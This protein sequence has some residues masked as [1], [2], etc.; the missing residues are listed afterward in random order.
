MANGSRIAV[1]IL[2]GT[3]DFQ[4]KRRPSKVDRQ[5]KERRSSYPM[6]IRRRYYKVEK[7]DAA[8]LHVEALL[9]ASNDLTC[10]W[11]V[12]A[13]EKA[14]RPRG[15]YMLRQGICVLDRWPPDRG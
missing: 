15:R 9:H 12:S 14:R 4:I 8:E 1:A 5:M 2:N 13:A 10:A 6:P 7:W 11:I 3:G